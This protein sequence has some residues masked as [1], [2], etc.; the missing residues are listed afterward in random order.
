MTIR[1]LSERLNEIPESYQDAECKINVNGH[2]F[3]IS[4]TKTESLGADLSGFYGAFEIVGILDGILSTEEKCDGVLRIPGSLTA[5]EVEEVT[6]KLKELLNQKG[7]HMM[8]ANNIKCDGCGFETKIWMTI[9][10]WAIVDEL[11][12]CRK[13]Q[14]RLKI[15]WYAE[16]N[17]KT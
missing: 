4:H 9:D 8:P 2:T 5:E 6:L 7:Q 3:E 16:K 12:Y 15:G 11:S 10:N 17:D 14:K 1:K 13:C